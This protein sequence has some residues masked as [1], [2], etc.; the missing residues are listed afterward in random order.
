VPA[1][2]ELGPRTLLARRLFAGLAP[3][4]DRAARVLSLGQDPRWRRFLASR[5]RGAG[6][7]LDVAS[8]TAAVAMEVARVTGGRVVGLD[9]SEPM[10]REGA[11]RVARAGLGRRVS[12]V[13]GRGE[14]L[15]FADRSFDAVTFAYLLRYVDD[16]GAT[17]R[18]LARVLRP[19]GAMA[20]L[21]FAVPRGPALRGLW[22]AYVRGVLPLAGRAISP[23]WEDVGRFLGPSILEFHRRH[24]LPA[25]LDLW[26]AAGIPH[27]R[28]WTMSLGG[29][30][31]VWGTKGGR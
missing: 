7:V 28:A 18:E 11:A 20:G 9:Q 21:E 5:V 12:L 2:P 19:G 31:V 24:P 17:L 4:Y 10:L 30:V 3:T 14:R 25:Q 13:L 26:R 6:L 1:A 8:G 23:S 15:P 27:P 22:R 16:P 29:A